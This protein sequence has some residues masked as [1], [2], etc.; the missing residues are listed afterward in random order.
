[1]TKLSKKIK[2]EC[3][4][5]VE[6][7]VNKKWEEMAEYIRRLAKEVLGVSK[8]ELGEWKELGGGVKR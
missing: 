4:W 6:G 8:G 2:M 7:D 1:M 5:I 3:K